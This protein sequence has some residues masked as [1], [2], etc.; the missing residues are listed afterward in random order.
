[1]QWAMCIPDLGHI[2][3]T[4]GDEFRP[5]L[6]MSSFPSFLDTWRVGQEIIV[7]IIDIG[8]GCLFFGDVQRGGLQAQIILNCEGCV[9]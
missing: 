9:V 7:I 8:G 1:M 6:W 3:P 4:S 2:G 5:L